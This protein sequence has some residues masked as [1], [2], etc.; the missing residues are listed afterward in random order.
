MEN[1]LA[2]WLLA[3]APIILFLIVML[4]FKWGVSRAGAFAWLITAS[5][6]WLF[7]GAD[8][9]LIG[10]TYVKGFLLAFDVLLIIWTAMFFFLLTEKAGTIQRIGSWLSE[11]TD[12]RAAKGILL[13]WLFPSFLQGI[14]GFGVP[15][16]VSAPLL[17]SSGFSPVQ[18]IVMASVG[19]AWGIT[20][21][22]MASSFQAL[23]AVSGLPGPLLAPASAFLLGTVALACGVMVCF[24]ADGWQ[25]VRSMLPYTLLLGGLLGAGQYL[26]AANQL[27]IISVTVPAL[28]ALVV[29]LF[30]L[31]RN[32]NRSSAL[33]PDKK[34]D[35]KL[36]LSIIPYGV[37]IA[38]TLAVNLVRPLNQL[39]NRYAFTLTFPE[40]TTRF[41]DITPGGPGRVIHFFT[42]P[43]A[44]IALSALASFVLFVRSGLLEKTDLW[45]TVKLTATK[46]ADTSVAILTMV[47]IAT[48]MSHTRMTAILAEGIAT[49]F[50]HEL[51]PLSSPF[52]GALGAFITGNNTNSNVLFASI[53][54]RSAEMLGL[55]VPLILA[56]QT[57]G[58]AIG[59]MMAPAKIILACATVG[60]ENQE[61]MVISRIL[62]YGLGLVLLIGLMTL[63]LSRF[64][65]FYAEIY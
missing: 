29:G 4:V 62:V 23:I 60:L 58:G 50:R 36:F 7:F 9:T 14:G 5:I 52:I 16:A 63:F 21:G 46:S 48:I 11:M 43:A 15:V 61:G 59:S 10:Y 53:Q 40:I 54:M 27:W 55:S 2:Y 32:H 6:A 26:L 13:G 64:G 47:G 38:V 22:S 42:H 24:I 34:K 25:G 31:G 18:A 65:Y 28:A 56:A 3:A 44:M 8:L 30:T 1:Y 49:A 20:F 12:S 37:L 41:G 35:K 51:F 33:D 17:V 57:A 39:L 19:H 45:K